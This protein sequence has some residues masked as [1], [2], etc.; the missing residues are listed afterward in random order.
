MTGTK[1]RITLAVILRVLFPIALAEA[2]LLWIMTN[3]LG[4]IHGTSWGVNTLA[5]QL[6]FD[7][8][9]RAVGAGGGVSNVLLMA[10]V[11]GAAVLGT[12]VLNG[13]HNFIGDV[14]EKKMSGGLAMRIHEKASRLDP[15]LFEDPAMLDDI[16]KAREGA[17]NSL[18]LLFTVTTIFIF[19]LPYF[20][21]MGGYLFVLKPVLAF[22]LVL[23]F[24]PVAATQLIRGT[25][26]AKLEDRAAPIRREYEYYEQCICDREYF[27]ETRILGGFGYFRSLYR[28]TLELLSGALWTAERRT[29][30][31]ELA[32][33]MLTLAGYFGILFL[34]FRALLRGEISIGAF[35]AVFASIGLMFNIMEE[36]VCSHIGTMTRN[37]GTV[38]NFIRFLDL[39]ERGGAETTLHAGDGVSLCDAS[40]R[41][42]GADADCVRG[43]SLDVRKGEIIAIVGENGAGKT[44]LVR[45]MTGLYLPREGAV[46]VGGVDTRRVSMASVY[47]GIS[48][49]FQNYQRYKMTLG[50]NISISGARPDSDAP[51]AEAS[52]RA[53]L[54]MSTDTFPEG[55]A[56]M[57]SREFDGVDL[58][59]GQWQRVAIARGFFRAHGLIV[60]DEPTAAIDPIEETRIFGKFAEMARGKTAVIVTHRLGSAK[61]ADRIVVMVGGRIDSIGSHDEL[62]L[63]GGKYAEMFSAQAKW[64]ER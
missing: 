46:M 58:S 34:L 17:N 59:G 28:T 54:D 60:L 14:F 21:F 45:L 9:A 31:W 19:Y 24:V 20:L 27:K 22:S 25:V 15:V 18:G 64:Y 4:V 55:Y 1:G 23:V 7:S 3:L 12:Q 57:L 38:R 16:N 48:A 32:M 63:A 39:P 5:T 61:I 10:L 42:P 43:V 13:V 35:S 51:L 26:F 37:L 47:R 6:F 40:F 41:Y 53:E 30:L 50:E 2:P 33:K 56:T 62:M 8:V 44:T 11:M 52:A 29:G 36:V 49:V